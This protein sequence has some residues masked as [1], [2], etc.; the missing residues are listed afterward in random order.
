MSWD[1]QMLDFGK[2]AFF[3]KIDPQMTSVGDLVT[4][5]KIKM[6]KKGHKDINKVHQGDY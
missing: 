3:D 1:Y 6:F 5:I 4:L 2:N